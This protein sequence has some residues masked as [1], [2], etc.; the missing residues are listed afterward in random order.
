MPTFQRQLAVQP[1][2]RDVFPDGRPRYSGYGNSDRDL[3]AFTFPLAY[4]A[5]L[6]NDGEYN[7]YWWGLAWEGPGVVNVDIKGMYTWPPYDR[8]SGRFDT[9]WHSE[10]WWPRRDFLKLSAYFF[11]RIQSVEKLKIT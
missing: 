2:L 1:A 5:K 11:D 7:R 6:I 9:S 8:A 4:A 10:K 3:N